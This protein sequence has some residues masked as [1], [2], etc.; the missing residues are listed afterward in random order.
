MRSRIIAKNP[1]I[2]AKTKPT[3]LIA[4]I[5]PVIPDFAASAN[6]NTLAPSIAGIDMINENLTANARL[7]PFRSPPVI[8]MP[9]RDIPGGTPIS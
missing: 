1:K 2:N 5:D 6:S 8:V 4:T 9:E 7:K 3:A